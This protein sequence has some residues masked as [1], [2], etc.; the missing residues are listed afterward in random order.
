MERKG[1]LTK[2]ANLRLGKGKVEEGIEK[3]RNRKKEWGLNTFLFIN[4][5]S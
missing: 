5:L 1:E 2:F 4:S 3:G